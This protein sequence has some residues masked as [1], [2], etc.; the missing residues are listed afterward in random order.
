MRSL[1]VTCLRG[2][3]H[4][5]SEN[6]QQRIPG[7]LKTGEGTEQGRGGLPMVHCS[8]V[9]ST[10][11]V[12]KCISELKRDFAQTNEKEI[13]PTTWKYLKS[14]PKPKWYNH[15]SVQLGPDIE[16]WHDQRN[17]QQLQK[18]STCKDKAP[19]ALKTG[20]AGIFFFFNL[21]PTNKFSY[22]YSKTKKKFNHQNYKLILSVNQL[23]NA[24]YKILE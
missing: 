22:G 10:G 6:S 9:T 2:L 18:K 14:C 20:S 19:E 11:R 24:R 16:Y 13:F 1:R 8:A 3:K 17:H 7:W 21:S 12:R 15:V 23:Y 5:G 4:R